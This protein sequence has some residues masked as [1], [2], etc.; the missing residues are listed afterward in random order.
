MSDR[1]KFGMK[2]DLSRLRE[3]AIAAR[4]ARL[5][6]G[7]ARAKRGNGAFAAIREA[8]PTIDELLAN[9]SCEWPDVVRALT[10]QGVRTRKGEPLTVPRLTSLIASV[11][12]Q[13]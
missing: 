1:M 7:D 5:E 11:R 13:K 6:A 10:E 2:I 4:A 9:D 12:K 8:L 3:G